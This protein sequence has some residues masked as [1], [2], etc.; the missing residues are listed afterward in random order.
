M[1][2]KTE[3]E[4][5]AA[6]DAADQMAV[7]LAR[8]LREGERVFHGVNSPLPMVA[9]FLAKKLHAPGS[10]LIEVAGSVDPR[11]ERLPFST[12]DP[13]LCQGAAAIF[14]NA[15][16]YD[17]FAR[18]GVDLMYL[19]GAQIDKAGRVNMSY[20]GEPSAPKVRLPGGGGG[21][22]IMEQARRIVIW[23]VVHDRR[24]FVEKVDFVTQS[25]NL[26]RVVT[27]LAV[28]EMRDEG[29][30]LG[31]VHPCVSVVEVAGRTGFPLDLGAEIPVTIPPTGDELSALAEIDPA[32]V[33]YSE[34]AALRRVER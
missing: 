27:P 12:N 28:M 25:G 8:E 15:D 1:T 29:L 34:F 23:R 10:V 31:S 19:G 2:L 3:S 6:R 4:I 21:S 14:S 16:A 33:R 20:I 13:A 22:V 7:C 11:P 30:Q 5:Q 18:G 24:T 26:A 32:G 9:I 17:L